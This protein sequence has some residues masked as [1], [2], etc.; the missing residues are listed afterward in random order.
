MFKI[1][2]QIRAGFTCNPFIPDDLIRDT[3]TINGKF[4]R[5]HAYSGFYGDFSVAFSFV[6]IQWKQ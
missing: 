3:V 4:A 1:T 5:T 6:G 2:P